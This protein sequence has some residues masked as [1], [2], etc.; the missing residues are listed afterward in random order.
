MLGHYHVSVKLADLRFGRG[1]FEGLRICLA[2][3]RGLHHGPPG[4]RCMVEVNREDKMNLPRI[5]VAIPFLACLLSTELLARTPTG[6]VN[7]TVVDT[8]G[9]IVPDAKVTVV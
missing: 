9:G 7:G 6:V 4:G 2:G 3:G 5:A 1:A 8:T